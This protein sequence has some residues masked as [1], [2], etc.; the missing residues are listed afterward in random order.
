[1][2]TADNPTAVSHR[3]RTDLRIKRG[4]EIPF[5]RRILHERDLRT[6]R[7]GKTRRGYT[8][9]DSIGDFLLRKVG[10]KKTVGFRKT[11]TDLTADTG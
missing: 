8:L 3:Y 10:A 11:A 5:P 2:D 9:G 1:M 4:T 7:V 6:G